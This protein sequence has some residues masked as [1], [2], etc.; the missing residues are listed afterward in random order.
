MKTFVRLLCQKTNSRK[1]V[2]AEDQCEMY[3]HGSAMVV[4]AT[5]KWLRL[6]FPTSPVFEP[7][8]CWHIAKGC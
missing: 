5:T 2:R 3:I 8:K 1:K 4:I 6:P 7:R